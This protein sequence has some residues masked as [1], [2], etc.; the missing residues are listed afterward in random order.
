MQIYSDPRSTYYS[1]GRRDN[2][3]S[4]DFDLRA[5]GNALSK[6]DNPG[7]SWGLDEQRIH[8]Y[9]QRQIENYNRRILTED[10]LRRVETY[11]AAGRVPWIHRKLHRLAGRFSVK[12]SSLRPYEQDNRSTSSLSSLELRPTPPVTQQSQKTSKK[13]STIGSKNLTDQERLNH[14]VHRTRNVPPQPNPT[15]QASDLFETGYLL[16]P[17]LPPHPHLIYQP[18]RNRPLPPSPS[19]LKKKQTQS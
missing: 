3:V 7:S 1:H 16:N 9:R 19:I 2:T 13:N 17:K 6:E 14:P 11:P 4:E 5:V 10:T 18:Y 15:F 12:F 8:L